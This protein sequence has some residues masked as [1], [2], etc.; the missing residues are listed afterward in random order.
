MKKRHEEAQPEQPAPREP[1]AALK[2]LRVATAAAAANAAPKLE[3]PEQPDSEPPAAALQ[4]PEPQPH[5]TARAPKPSS[6]ALQ[7]LN[8]QR[9]AADNG[10]FTDEPDFEKLAP[11]ARVDYEARRLAALR[12]HADQSREHMSELQD[13]VKR[14]DGLIAAERERVAS[15]EEAVYRA[16]LAG[17]ELPDSPVSNLPALERTKDEM[18]AKLAKATR[19][20]EHDERI[21]HNHSRLEQ[22]QRAVVLANASE[23]AA[24]KIAPLVAELRAML[25]S[26][27]GEHTFNVGAT[28]LTI[29]ITAADAPP[30]VEFRV[31]SVWLQKLRAQ[32]SAR[33]AVAS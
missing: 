31:G 2:K 8:A 17:S 30:S 19:A 23:F 27:P 13:T 6:I 28:P 15:H 33:E 10:K 20:Y 1:S 3:Q 14:I 4:E 32:R 21:A 12:L 16:A 26:A 25:E 18:A 7:K 29:E 9:A 24:T 5:A 11:Q 22:A